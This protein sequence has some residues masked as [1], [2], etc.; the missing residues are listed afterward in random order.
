[1]T[2]EPAD[3]AAP[4][5]AHPRPPRGP[6]P[7]AVGAKALAR[8]LS[9][10]LRSIRTWDAGGRLPR[11]IRIGGKVVWSVSEIRAWLEAGAPNRAEWDRR[12]R[13]DQP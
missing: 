4:T 2:D 3:T 6:M 9:C 1:M 8:M 12:R 13:H 5:A 10:G 7:L 11:P